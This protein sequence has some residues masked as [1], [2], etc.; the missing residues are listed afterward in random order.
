MQNTISIFSPAE[1]IYL[2]NQ[3]LGRLA[4]VSPKGQPHVVPVTFRYNPELKTID[5]GGHGFAQR[6][7]FR[8]VQHN[9]LVAFVVDD[10]PSVNPWQARGIEIRGTAEILDTGGQTIR[11]DFDPE[12]FRIRPERIISW[13]LD[14]P[15]FSA[16]ARSVS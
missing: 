1:I 7:K 15:A 5:I 16:N 13:G 6:K 8:D 11:P 3:F 9:A 2:Q 4:T 14:G 12:M 10:V